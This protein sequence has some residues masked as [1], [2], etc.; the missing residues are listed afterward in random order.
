ML[1][2]LPMDQQRHSS[3]RERWKKPKEDILKIKCDVSFSSSGG[4]G[5]VTR[6]VAGDVVMAGRG[7]VTYL[8]NT[9]QAEVL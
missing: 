9:F 8:L 6:D 1:Q 5:F 4:W 3:M 7:R 2:L